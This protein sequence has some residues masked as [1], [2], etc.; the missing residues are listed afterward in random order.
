MEE[1]VNLLNKTF[2]DTFKLYLKAH[3]YHW[4]VEGI[5]FSQYH[6]FFGKLYEEVHGSID[7]TAEHIRV[8]QAYVPGT[9][10]RISELSTI[11]DNSATDLKSM[12]TDLYAANLS[13]I[14]S[15]MLVNT[16]AERFNEVGLANYVQGRI[17]I[18]KKH[19]WM[20]RAS[21]KDANG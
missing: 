7:T 11:P 19:G 4:N 17:E 15:L 5:E 13:V 20:L 8:L 16:M 18:H 2:A 14:N 1:L 9:L 12:L 3:N 10:P 21:L 6:D